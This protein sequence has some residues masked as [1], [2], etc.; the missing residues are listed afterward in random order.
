MKRFKKIRGHKRIWREID[1]WFDRCKDLD[2]EYLKQNQRDYIKVWVPPYQNISIL[3]STFEPPK[4]ETRTKIVNGIFTIYERW[5][6]QLDTLNEPYYLKVWYYP[7]DVSKNQVVCAIGEALQFYDNTFF[8]PNKMQ[9]F[10]ENPRN[11]KWELHHQEIHVSE[12]DLEEPEMFA[13]MEDYREHT[14]WVQR[15]MQHPDARI[16]KSLNSEN[17]EITYYSLKECDVWI[18]G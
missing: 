17:K 9:T 8:N 4:G 2:L 10:P 18:G 14:R 5:K 6:S 7:H 1:H 11:L 15:I 3:N 12:Y 13:S 16:T